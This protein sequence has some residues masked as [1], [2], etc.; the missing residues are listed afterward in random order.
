MNVNVY[1]TV[2]SFTCC[3]GVSCHWF[4]VAISDTDEAISRYAII[5]DLYLREW[6]VATEHLSVSLVEVYA[7]I[8]TFLGKPI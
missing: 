5:E 2:F 1:T 3:S 4:S 6:Y 8:L 7:S